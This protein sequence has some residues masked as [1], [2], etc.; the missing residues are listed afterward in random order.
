MATKIT[1]YKFN[2]EEM[3]KISNATDV[4][5]QGQLLSFKYEH[6]NSGS[7]S[8][9]TTL[10]YYVEESEAEEKPRAWS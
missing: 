2:G 8:V 5:T 3:L 9:R 4:S 1:I 7:K 6:S 10:P